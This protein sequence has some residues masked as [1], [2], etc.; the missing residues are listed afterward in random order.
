MEVCLCTA[1]EFK[2]LTAAGVQGTLETTN[3]F[4]LVSNVYAVQGF[5]I[6]ER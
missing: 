6:Q 5:S 2:N 3:V 4:R 1:F